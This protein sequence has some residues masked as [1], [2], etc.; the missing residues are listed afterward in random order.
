MEAVLRQRKT[1]LP[2]RLLSPDRK[3]TS[4]PHARPSQDIKM[5]NAKGFFKKTSQQ[6]REID[7]SYLLEMES[8]AVQSR[9]LCCN[10]M[11]GLEDFP[12]FLHQVVVVEP[13]MTG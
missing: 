2:Y 7:Y 13:E 11:G 6:K 4:H 5:Y 3:R 8:V 10:L 9:E 1:N 12:L